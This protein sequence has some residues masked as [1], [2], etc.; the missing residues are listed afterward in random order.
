L[1]DQINAGSGGN[2]KAG[3]R[4]SWH[5]V[6]LAVDISR[7]SVTGAQW[8]EIVSD[9]TSEGFTWGGNFNYVNPTTGKSSYDPIHFQLAPTVTHPNGT[10][11]SGAPSL[12]SVLACEAAHPTGF[13]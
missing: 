3:A 10:I 4:Q 1:A 7:N 12:S 6:G 13:Y 5:E 8:S 2:P 9:M 11:S